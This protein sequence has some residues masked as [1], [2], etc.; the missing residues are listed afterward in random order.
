VEKNTE[1]TIVSDPLLRDYGSG[2][3]SVLI[4]KEF[5][6]QCKVTLI[7]PAI[8]PDLS[9]ML[10]RSKIEVVD[11]GIGS[12]FRDQSLQYFEYWAR[13]A[14]FGLNSRK[15]KEK[16]TILNFGN[17]LR[18]PCRAWF[19]QGS[20]V[21]VALKAISP[22]FSKKYRLGYYSLKDLLPRVEIRYIKKFRS[23]AD[24]VVANSSYCRSLYQNV[25]ITVD[26]IIPSPLDLE[27]FRP[28]TSSPSRDYVISYLGK[29][30]DTRVLREVASNGLRLKIFGAKLNDVPKAL[31]INP[32]IEILGQVEDGELADLYSNALFTIFP[33]FHEDFGY[34]PVESMACGT[35]V[36]TYGTQG[37]GEI[38]VDRRTGW[39]VN[40]SQ[41]MIA[42]A[43]KL[44]HLKGE[45]FDQ[46]TEPCSAQVKQY[47]SSK[48][49]AQWME[50][51]GMKK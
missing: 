7:T 47:E 2:R 17:T 50:L 40:D 27:L 32:N 23:R 6:K 5:A 4:A 9:E 15:L 39:H 11:L 8:S 18:T 3:P 37:P 24:R 1:I 16:D 42:T 34:I 44:W 19:T 29:E 46:M 41:E 38:V 45:G 30:T 49:A 51:L 35:P 25:G 26:D 14:F 31:S 33:F 48:V 13:E 10:H 21:Y 20:P 12:H 43:D 36:L 22:S 28:T